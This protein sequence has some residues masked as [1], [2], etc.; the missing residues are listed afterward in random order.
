MVK[1]DSGVTVVV[2]TYARVTEVSQTVEHLLGLPEHP[3][4]IVVDNGSGD[5]TADVLSRRFPRVQTIALRRN[6]GAAARNVGIREAKTPYVALCDDDTWWAAGSL[7]RAADVLNGHSGVAVV[8]GCV[9]V[10]PEGREDPACREMAKSPLV[11]YPDL[12]GRPI[13]GFLA[14]ASMIRRKAFLSVGGFEPRFFIG[15]EE[16]LVAVDLAA[17]GWTMLYV[18]EI[19]IHHHPSPRRDSK[20]R[21]RLLLR[22]A[23]WFTWLRRP[24]SSALR[25]TGRLLR[26]AVHDP[27]EASGLFDAVGGLLWVMRHRQCL[28]SEIEAA[29]LKLD[30]P[31][32]QT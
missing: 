27:Y 25:Q 8:T 11:V 9:L 30:K 31:A 24:L 32:T 10:G 14:G 17:A 21:R 1:S 6:I 28:P 4:V 19:V 26:A 7:R 22:N 2:L 13:L 12:P 15:G 23:L 3:P 20:S 29:L 5:G 16:A 18:P